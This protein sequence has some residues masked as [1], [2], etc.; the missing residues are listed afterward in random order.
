M[1]IS[2]LK[3]SALLYAGVS[4]LIIILASFHVRGMWMLRDFGNILW[5]F[6]FG[7]T[8]GWICKL[9]KWLRIVLL[10]CGLG[11]ML[12]TPQQ[13]IVDMFLCQYSWHLFAYILLGASVPSH[14]DSSNHNLSETMGLTLLFLFIYIACVYLSQRAHTAVYECP[15]DLVD[16]LNIR[17]YYLPFF[18]LL[19]FLYCF[20]Q[21]AVQEDVQLLM[22]N[23][24]MRWCV[25]FICIAAFVICVISLGGVYRGVIQLLLC[26]AVGGL[27]FMGMMKLLEKKEK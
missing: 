21:F 20:T 1:D 15:G 24:V 4:S 11:I 25:V 18:P 13:P 8:V 16:N 2:N 27:V 5:L 19:G 9:P 23:K 7:L 17:L 14:I 12:S 3:K 6:C 26:P 22:D 10:V